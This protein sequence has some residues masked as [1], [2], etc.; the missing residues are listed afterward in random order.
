MKRQLTNV[1]DHEDI[2]WC[3]HCEH[4]CSWCGTLESITDVGL[5]E[6][7]ALEHAIMAAE[8]AA[9]GDR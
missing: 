6:S 8:V 1:C 7:C 2:D 5:C 9:E 4:G 3:V